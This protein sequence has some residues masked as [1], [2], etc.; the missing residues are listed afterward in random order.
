MPHTLSSILWT[1]NLWE[2]PFN[3]YI[4]KMHSEALTVKPKTLNL[5]WNFYTVRYETIVY[6]ISAARLCH[7]YELVAGMDFAQCNKV[8]SF[9]KVLGWTRNTYGRRHDFVALNCFNI[10]KFM[11]YCTYDLVH[12]LDMTLLH[13]CEICLFR[14]CTPLLSQLFWLFLL[15]FRLLTCCWPAG[16]TRN[17]ITSLTTPRSA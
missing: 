5:W 14:R 4:V 10:C 9:Y 16:L 1:D 17:T 11:Q 12:F 2:F 15:F 7:S 3:I 8:V 13:W 6:R